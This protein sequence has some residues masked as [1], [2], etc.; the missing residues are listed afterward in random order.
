MPLQMEDIDKQARALWEK[1]HRE[2]AQ[3][4]S[5]IKAKMSEDNINVG[6]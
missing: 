6:A 1:T 4:K 3:R 5:K 2:N